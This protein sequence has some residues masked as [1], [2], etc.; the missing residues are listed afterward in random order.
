MLVHAALCCAPLFW[1][2]P[3]A[4]DPG[5]SPSARIAIIGGAFPLPQGDMAVAKLLEGKGFVVVGF[6]DDPGKR[7]AAAAI[8]AAFDAVL[9]SSTADPANIGGEFRAAGIPMV[10][11]NPGLL[12]VDRE[13][14]AE[15]GAV[16]QAQ[17]AITLVNTQ[18]PL[19][20][21][22]GAGTLGVLAPPAPMAAATGAIPADAVVL[23][24]R[25]ATSE[26]AILA[27]ESGAELLGG[28]SA[29]ARRVFLFFNDAGAGSATGAAWDLF[30]RSVCWAGD[31]SPVIE[32]GPL[33]LTVPPG[34][35]VTLAV[36]ARGAGPLT[37]LWRR[38]GLGLRDN[39]R[40]QGAATPLLLIDPLFPS[41]SGDYDVVVTNACGSATSQVGTL[42]VSSS[43]Y[44]NCDG[45][46]EFP[47]L[48]V[49]DFLC[50]QARFAAGDPYANCDESTSP[51]V[52]NVN[53]FLCFMA[54]YA[55]GCPG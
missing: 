32:S 51:P 50:F 55:Q 5:D 26:P 3:A 20:S 30:S 38:N 17:A 4:P 44:A 35:A 18:H 22:L 34:Y 9:V 25:G 1:A 7:P 13:A 23:A 41:D 16:A 43:C 19:T 2:I 21:G 28:Y 48:N 27:A 40:I 11:W 46:L 12:R 49:N 31:F 37:Y 36:A 8:A 33:S 45:S 10:L 6:D 52:L 42:T 54:R 29:P 24:L 14:L 47:V 39:G 15:G 53:D